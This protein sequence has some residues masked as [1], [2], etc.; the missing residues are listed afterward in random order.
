MPHLPVL[1]ETEKAL[2]VVHALA[3]AGMQPLHPTPPVSPL[4]DTAVAA[5]WR[6]RAAGLAQP[7]ALN[8]VESKA[9]LRSYG[10]AVSPEILTLS[11]PD[12]VAAAATIGF[13][14]VL[15]A[16]S[17]TV[18]H[19]TEAGLVILGVPDVDAASKAAAALFE[20]CRVLQIEPDGI[21]VA[22]HMPAG[23]ETVIGVANDA[24]MGPAVMF[25]SGGVWV[26]LIQ[27]VAF[28]PACLD[29]AQA[30]AMMR[31]TR[32]GRLLDGY[33][34]KSADYTSVADALVNLGRLANDFGDVLAAVDINPFVVYEQ[35]ACA[36]DA[37]VVLRPPRYH[38]NH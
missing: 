18:A 2:R 22:K 17:A 29:Q 10:I 28:A 38:G 6:A 11:A 15:K 8:E 5:H 25:G 7:T 36:L 26:E 3:T 23:I 12:A 16:I 37:L 4:G 14:V 20:R 9:L 35:G 31:T 24:E 30:L 19:K 33:R 1:R 27:D 34:G 13:P 21:L 32:A